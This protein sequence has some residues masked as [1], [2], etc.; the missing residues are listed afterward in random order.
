MIIFIEKQRRVGQPVRGRGSA[1]VGEVILTLTY[2][3]RGGFINNNELIVC[4]HDRDWTIG[5]THFMPE[6]YVL[7][8]SQY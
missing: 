8:S 6:R 5:H 1:K 3:D 4:V 7:H 2:R